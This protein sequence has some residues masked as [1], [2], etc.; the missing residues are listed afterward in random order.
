MH[1]DGI[2]LMEQVDDLADLPAIFISAYGRD[3]IPGRWMR[4]RRLRWMRGRRLH[5]Q[6]VLTNGADGAGAGGPAPASRA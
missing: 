5:R 2:E 3:E 6:T 1:T 4:G